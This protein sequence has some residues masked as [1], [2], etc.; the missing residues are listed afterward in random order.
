MGEASAPILGETTVLDAA[1]SGVVEIRAV[2]Y[3]CGDDGICRIRSLVFRGEIERA[4][5][6]SEALDLLDLVSE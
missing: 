1:G 3:P 2:Y 6:G 4:E 5:A